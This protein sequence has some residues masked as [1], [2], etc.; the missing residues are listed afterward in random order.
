VCEEANEGVQ[1]PVLERCDGST[2]HGTACPRCRVEVYTDPEEQAEH[3]EGAMEAGPDG[4]FIFRAEGRFRYRTLTATATDDRNTSALSKALTC[5]FA[6]L[7]PTPG[8]GTPHAPTYTPTR[9]IEGWSYLP[10]VARDA[11]FG[12]Q[13]GH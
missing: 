10:L 5:G 7:T 6:T 3:F 2:V 1:P 13:G 9:E 11:V 4:R 8:F 12:P